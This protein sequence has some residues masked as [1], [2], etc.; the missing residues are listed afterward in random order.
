MQLKAI[1]CPRPIKQNSLQLTAPSSTQ[2][3]EKNKKIK[4]NLDEFFDALASLLFL[5]SSISPQSKYCSSQSGSAKESVCSSLLTS[6]IYGFKGL[7]MT[8][9]NSTLISFPFRVEL[10]CFGP[11]LY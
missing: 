4:K 9:T 11:Q 2:E 3:K 10:L 6:C 7:R 5:P 1:V 8:L